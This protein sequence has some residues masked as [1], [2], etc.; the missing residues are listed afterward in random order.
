MKA[1]FEFLKEQIIEILVRSPLP[2]D[3]THG[4]DTV[5]WLLSLN[6]D[7]DECLKIAA[8]SHDIERGSENRLKGKDFPDYDTFKIYHAKH[9]AEI[10]KEFLERHEVDPDD[11]RDIVELV[12][13][14]EVGG[15]DRVDQL[16]WADSLSFFSNNLRFF[17]QS[18]TEEE[19]QYRINWGLRRLPKHLHKLI[20]EHIR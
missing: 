16:K 19:I 5:R 3:K 7:A 2:E 10:M 17:R 18:H 6:P 4:E 9:S 20:E 8:L 13:L 1:S 14:H 15:N 12:E 11:V